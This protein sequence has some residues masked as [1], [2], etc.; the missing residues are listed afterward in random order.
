VGVNHVVLVSFE[1]IKVFL[2]K[3]GLN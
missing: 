2:N 3:V 1:N